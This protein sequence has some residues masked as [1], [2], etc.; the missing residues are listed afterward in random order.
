MMR[1][2]RTITAEGIPTPSP[3]ARPLSYA[4]FSLE[5]QE[6]G[7]SLQ[8][9]LVKFQIKRKESHA[10]FRYKPIVLIF[11]YYLAQPKSS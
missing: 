5:V 1:Q 8:Y 9:K 3:T 2:K 4:I 11:Y 10:V 6:F 7:V